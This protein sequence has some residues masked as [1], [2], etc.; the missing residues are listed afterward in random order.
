MYDLSRRDHFLDIK[1]RINQLN[2]QP[3]AKVDSRDLKES[4]FRPAGLM[5]RLVQRLP[6]GQKLFETKNCTVDCFE[7]R[8]SLFPCTHGYLN[9]DRQWE[10]HASVLL[11]DGRVQ[12]VEF[13]VLDGV[14]AAPNFLEKF[15]AI[16]TEHFGDPRQEQKNQF[17]WTNDRL[18]FSGFLHADN[19]T[20]NFTIECLDK[21]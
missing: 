14:Y 10:T 15:K 9:N 5:R 3:G 17:H 16:C 4:E 21:D 2:L 20:A 19:V 7:D 11:V 8:L 6:R 18:G 13:R 12:K 1:L